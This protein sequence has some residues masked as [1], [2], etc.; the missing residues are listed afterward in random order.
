MTGAL[1]DDMSALHII[2][3]RL[4]ASRHIQGRGRQRMIEKVIAAFRAAQAATR[5]DLK[6]PTL[7]RQIEAVAAALLERKRLTGGEVIEIL[8]SVLEEAA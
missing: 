2:V 4:D 7:W 1:V 8:N 6:S 3:R 5:K